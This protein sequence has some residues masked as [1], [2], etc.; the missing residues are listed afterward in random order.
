MKKA[1]SKFFLL[2]ICSTSFSVSFAESIDLNTT[3]T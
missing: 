1:I 2:L 3:I